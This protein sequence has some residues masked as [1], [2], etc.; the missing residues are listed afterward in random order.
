[1]KR[2]DPDDMARRSER[3]VEWAG[4]AMLV[5]LVVGIA[6]SFMGGRCLLIH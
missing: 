6:L 2:L 1:M 4:W 5:V 3:I